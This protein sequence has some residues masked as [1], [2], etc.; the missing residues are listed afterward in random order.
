MIQCYCGSGRVYDKCC[1]PLVAGREHAV[2]AEAL[3]RSR[4][5]A[6]CV[7]EYGYLE[8][9]ACPRLH[10]GISAEEIQEWSTHMHWNKLTVLRVEG[11]SEQDSRGVVEFQA[12][13][14]MRGVPQILH[15]TSTFVRSD[16]QWCYED[17]HVHSRTIR[18]EAPKTGRN[19]P[20][21]C[22]SGQKFKKCCGRV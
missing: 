10:G 19:A 20:C 2:T 5:S 8:V 22:G 9:T 6:H 18:R 3:M 1:G 13:Y 12:E 14:T 16:R 7:G 17:G 15:E 11:G 4:F 21:A